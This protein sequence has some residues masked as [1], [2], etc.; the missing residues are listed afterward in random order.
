[1]KE[2][3]MSVESTGHSSSASEASGHPHPNYVGIAVFL[4]V[5]TILEVAIV[6]FFKFPLG[7]T[8]AS[9]I[10]LMFLKAAGVALYYMH[11]RYD[12][13]VFTFLM[14]GGAAVATAVILAVA[15]LNN[16]LPGQ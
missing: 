16:I 10:I 15:A 8:T 9:L 2:S 1:M 13:R 5:V 12:S 4:F 3:T 6:L 14:M 11:L 7:F